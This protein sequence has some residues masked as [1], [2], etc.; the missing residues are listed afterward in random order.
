MGL[1]ETTAVPTCLRLDH[2]MSE[3]PET[4]RISRV[5]DG[6]KWGPGWDMGCMSGEQVRGIAEM[7]G[8]GIT[9]TTHTA[10][11]EIFQ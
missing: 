6:G 8:G 4:R 2:V 1:D 5:P 3:L 11:N 7:S 10:Q 9:A